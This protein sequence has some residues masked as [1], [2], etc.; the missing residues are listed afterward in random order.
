MKKILIDIVKVSIGSIAFYLTLTQISPEIEKNLEWT[1]TQGYFGLYLII[2]PALTVGL[3]Y[4]LLMTQ[5]IPPVQPGNQKHKWIFVTIILFIISAFI[6]LWA[7]TDVTPIKIL[8]PHD[9]DSVF[10][11]DTVKGFAKNVPAGK[12]VWILIYSD[13][14]KVYYPNQESSNVEADGNWI[15]PATNFGANDDFGKKFDIVVC[16]VDIYGRQEIEQYFF[17]KKQFGLNDIPHG[18]KKCATISVFRK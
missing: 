8:Y 17:K 4:S 2:L 7:R 14:D 13:S 15:S 3:F 12:S 10:F 16:L 6:I 5:Q 18:V 9:K 1:K 11:Y